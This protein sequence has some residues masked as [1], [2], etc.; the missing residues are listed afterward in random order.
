MR[1]VN[2]NCL[3]IFL[4]FAFLQV[5]LVATADPGRGIKFVENKSQW[6]GGYDY[7]ANIPGGFFGVQPGLF[8]YVFFNEQQ[9]DQCHANSHHRARGEVPLEMIDGVRVETRFNGANPHAT[10]SPIDQNSD[11]TNY[12]N[13]ADTRRW[14]SDVRN[15]Q[16]LLYKELYPGIDLKLYSADRN[17][18]YDFLVQAGADP[19][20]IRFHYAGADKVVQT[21]GGDIEVTASW[22]LFV[23]KKPVAYQMIAGRRVVVPCQYLVV[24]G[25]ISFQ[26]PEGYD[27]CHPLVIDPLLIFSTYSGSTADNWGSTATPGERGT[28]Y[29][30]G[31]TWT[32]PFSPYPAGRFPATSGAFQTSLAG[33]FDIAILKYDSTGSKLL[34]ATY[35]GGKETDS[36]HSLVVSKDNSLLVLGTTSSPDFP[37]AATAYDHTFDGGTS[38]SGVVDYGLGSDIL[39]TKF[40]SDGK[41]LL[42][43]T[44]LGGLANDGLNEGVLVQNYGDQQ[45]GD[46]ITDDVGNV[47]IA[48]VSA[49]EDF[50]IVNGLQNTF[51]GGTTDAVVVKMKADLSAILW[52]TFIGGSGA[53][54]CHTM[55]FDKSG[56]LFI[57][58][59]TSSVEFPVTAGAYQSSYNGVADGWIASLSADGTT[60]QRA[61]Y[62][63]TSSF[64]EVFFVDLNASDEVYVYGQTAGDFPVTPGVYSNPHSGQFIQKFNHEL[65]SL[66]F[67]TVVGSGR[68]IP[69]ISP[70]AFLVNDCNNI[71][72]TGWGGVVNIAEDF[73]QN[74][75]VGMPVT[76]D[77][78][79]STTSGSDFYFMVLTDDATQF[80]YGTYMGGTL[81]RTHV[82]GGT[83]RFDKGGIVYHAVCAGCGAFNANGREIGTS[84]FPATAG[85]WSTRNRSYNC[86]NAAFKFDLS[87]LKARLQSNSIYLN[88]PGLNKL[89]MPDPIVFQNFSTGGETFEWDLGDGTKLVKHDTSL[90][91]HQYLNT[92]LYTVWLKAIDKGTCKVKDSVSTKV[93]V[94]VGHI[95]VQNDDVLCQNNP[96]TLRASGGVSYLWRTP[97]NSFQSTLQYPTV[98]PNDTTEYIIRVTEQ[99]GCIRDDTVK[100]SVIPTILPTFDLEQTAECVSRP[101]V[102]VAS[103]TDSLWQN[104]HLYFDLGDGTTSDET[105]I[106]HK[107]E[108]DGVFK[109]RLILVRDQCV[110]EEDVTLPVY[111]LKIPNVITPGGKDALND[112]FVIQ[113]GPEGQTPAQYGFKTSVTIFNRW[114]AEVYHSDDYQYDWNGEGLDGGVYYYEVTIQDHATCKS[115]LHLIK[116]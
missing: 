96:Y 73:W 55:K 52:S 93:N 59:G 108:K 71:Y 58:G 45:R 51:Q 15:Y 49:S 106:T 84:D 50:P 31:V 43:G 7:A 80:L 30:A 72:I 85:A 57:A 78:Y 91:V 112:N 76:S 9:I 23:E 48:S 24:D 33:A 60:W 32:S 19:T 86:N 92:G 12:Y 69:D 26:F 110:T 8:T 16:A 98:Q 103:T 90:V 10:V 88:Q 61:T 3:A 67:S 38:T 89:C 62:T 116:N 44:L 101:I 54:A 105:D 4:V 6:T 109:V 46:I 47:Y 94:Y 18:K 79:Q 100:L 13:G 114:G 81:S 97:D 107:Y 40:S 70:T 27:A 53:D 56:N 74:N 99:H 115:W 111:E 102:H 42:A 1:C 28:L 82:D 22:P 66:K 5:W 104:D 83:S 11:Y 2:R 36:P 65:T 21:A 75:T 41:S 35:L 95:E 39:I 17:L 25:T 37:T 20:A 77:A 113:Y 64:D 87:S 63:G 29:S 68:G 34:Y 14:A